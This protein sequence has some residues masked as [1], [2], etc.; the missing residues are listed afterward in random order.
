MADVLLPTLI[1]GVLLLVAMG[2]VAAIGRAWTGS[3]PSLSPRVLL[4]AYLYLVVLAST[5]IAAA[6]VGQIVTAG[7]GEGLGREFS[8]RT[9]RS[10]EPAKMGRPTGV[11]S[12]TAEE[13]EEERQRAEQQ[14]IE[15]MENEH[16]DALA[17]GLTALIVGGLVGILHH[18]AR[19]RIRQPGDQ[20]T[21]FF[22]RVESILGL[23]LFSILGISFAVTGIY[24][25]VRYLAFPQVGSFGP[26][27]SP[28]GPLGYALAFVPL[29]LIRLRSFVASV[30]RETV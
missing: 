24:Q 15:Q 29:W 8:Y 9:Y 27:V 19:R 20:T 6:G 25:L 11:T 13:L 21:R 16:R 23:A 22:D 5:I 12:P 30:N 14:R 1:I 7:L 3:A 4:A 2:A 10:P 17:Q 18:A 26:T 28:G